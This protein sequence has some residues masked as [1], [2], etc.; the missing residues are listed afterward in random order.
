MIP[1]AELMQVGHPGYRVFLS[2]RNMSSDRYPLF[3]SYCLAV[4]EKFRYH[5]M[6]HNG[7]TYTDDSL[8]RVT[9]LMRRLNETDEPEDV[10]PIREELRNAVYEFKHYCDK[11]SG[12]FTRPNSIREFYIELGDLVL[13]IAFD[14]A[15]L[16]DNSVI[17][18]GGSI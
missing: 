4:D 10:F 17:L 16:A 9:M 8:M 2:G 14:F 11:M 13:D 6:E 15:G 3:L 5:A 1:I 7:S 18:G 12:R